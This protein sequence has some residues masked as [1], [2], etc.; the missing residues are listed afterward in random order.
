MGG[1]ETR[2]GPGLRYSPR[3]GAVKTAWTP[4]RSRAADAST[5]MRRPCACSLRTNATC[6][7]PGSCTSSTNSARPVSSRASSLRGTRALRYGGAA[8]TLSGLKDVVVA[9]AS[10]EIR[11][12]CIANFRIRGCRVLFQ[13]RRE[14]HE[15]SRRA[16]AALQA[17]RVAESVL[18][19]VQFA[20]GSGKRF[21]RLKIVSIRLDREHD[22]GSDGLAI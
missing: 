17:M 22:A 12:K 16:K 19:R 6:S 13:E 9:R 11:R 10:A 14:R 4:A 15:K 5:V 18:Q 8:G 1:G 2:I 3:S 20:R 7:I 21:N